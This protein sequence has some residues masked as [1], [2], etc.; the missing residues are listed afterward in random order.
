[1]FSIFRIDPKAQP[2]TV[3]EMERYFAPESWQRLL[4]ANERLLFTG[5][6]DKLEVEI[7]RLDGTRGWCLIHREAVRDEAGKIGGVRGIALDVT[8]RMRAELALREAEEKYRG[9]FE[10]AV[11]GIF[12]SD[13]SGRYLSVNP[14]MARMLGY[15]SPQELITSVTDIA[16]QVYVDPKSREAFRLLVEQQGVVQNFEC[17]AYRKDGSK[18]WIT[19]SAHAVR[20]DGAVIGYEGTN[21]DITERKLLEEELR[22]VQKMEAVGRLAGGVAHDF[23]NILGVIMGYADLSLGRLAPEDTVKTY[24]AQ[25][26]KAA[27]RAV[28]LTQQ[29]LA[30]SR[31]QIVFPKLLDLNV[32][33]HNLTTMLLRL[34]REDIAIS[35]RPTT[36]IDSINADQGQIEQI[37]MNLVV[38]A[39]DA[40]SSGGQ[41]TIGTGHAELDE[42]F[43]LHNP[44]SRAGQYVVLTVSDT[45]CGMDENT[46]SHIFEPFFTTKEIGQGTGLGL[47]TVYG[48]VKQSGGYI[49]VDSEP[50][51]GATFKI[52]FPRVA[53]KAEELVPFHGK[54]ELPKGSETILVVED[55][56]AL[57]ELAACLLQDAGYRVIEATDAGTALDILQVEPGIDLLLTDVIMP[58]KTGVELLEQAKAL[59]P[60]LRS[61]FMSGYPGD[62]VAMRGGLMAETAFLEK[63]FNQSSL[64]TKVYSAL[65]SKPAKQQSH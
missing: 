51:K 65:H 42:H 43:T 37:L 34:V 13:L 14:A 23:R 48:I 28:S 36:P 35:F 5:E 22:Q 45:G 6:Q 29:L 56:E 25:I 8:D 54:S 27:D 10:S 49:W 33:V 52:Y 32:V 20:K 19:I 15:G 17:Q 63:P 2:P 9:I 57:R 31:R 16:Q 11:V 60:N 38:N 21:M 62:L 50:G 3:N 53:E 58:G 44:G 55:D 18:I 39:R 1:M 26:K 41:I 59:H 47:S 64:L 46:I 61:L 4:Q 30:F 24:Q 12:Q 40:M 7:R